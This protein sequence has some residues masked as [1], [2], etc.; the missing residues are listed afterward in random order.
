MEQDQM[1]SVC[2]CI[3]LVRPLGCS[4]LMYVQWM[5]KTHHSGNNKRAIGTFDINTKAATGAFYSCGIY[6][7]FFKLYQRFFLI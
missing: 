4:G 3:I 5:E 6:N 1:G 2:I 7:L